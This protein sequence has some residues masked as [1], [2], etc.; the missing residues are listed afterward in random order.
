MLHYAKVYH[1]GKSDSKVLNGDGCNLP[2]CHILGSFRV[3]PCLCRFDRIK[4]IYGYLVAKYKDA[5]IRVRTKV[6]DF[7]DL[8]YEQHNWSQCLRW[9]QGRIAGSDMSPRV[10]LSSCRVTLTPICIT[11]SSCEGYE[12]TRSTLLIKEIF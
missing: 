4:R 9:I 1:Q 12:M 8:V 10:N 5:T 2:T 6:S 11:T 7:S 3:A